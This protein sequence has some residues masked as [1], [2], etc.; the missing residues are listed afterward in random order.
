LPDQAKQ[1][2]QSVLYPILV[3]QMVDRLV[4]LQEA[5]RAGFDKDP[6]VQRQL[7]A[8]A[9]RTLLTAYV[10]E[11]I[12]KTIPESAIEARYAK[13]YGGKQG[14]TEV[15]ARHILVESEADAKA[16]IAELKKGGDFAALAKAK[17]KD[18]GAA[19]GGDLGWFK[20]DDMV[21]A[22]ADAAFA[23]KPG[24][25]SQTPV[26]TQFGWHV[27]KVEEV[28]QDPPP[29]LEEVQDQIRQTLFNEAL[30]AAVAKGRGEMKVE[31]FNMD[32]TPRK[33]S[34]ATPAAAAAAAPAPA[35]K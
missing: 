19:Q 9:D 12:A 33:D 21:P 8:A 27:I 4:L 28:K 20:H 1:M 6:A 30:Q 10:R 2:P 31:R 32:G 15:H 5:R 22:F 29:K 24:E 18:S 16:I 14:E 11:T 17:S 25:Y 35:P 26:K 3:D 7:A 13:D 23:L 34:A